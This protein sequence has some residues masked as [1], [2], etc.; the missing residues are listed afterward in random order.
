M[1]SKSPTSR[2]LEYVRSQGWNADIV[3]KFN[4]HVGKFGKRKDLFG[5]IDIIALTDHDIMGIQSCGQA[6]SEH[7]RKILAEPLALTW[8]KRGGVL[9][10]IGW[11]KLKVKRGGKAL[12]WSPRIKLYT[13]KDFL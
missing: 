5:I 12:R 7:N 2:T 8:L 13:E 10:L 1:P 9:M 3:E 6:Y 11:R 4:P